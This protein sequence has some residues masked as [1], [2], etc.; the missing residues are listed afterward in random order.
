MKV[1]LTNPGV[2]DA[3]V[4]ICLL[5]SGK[6]IFY[7][8]P[9]ASS[10]LIVVGE[11]RGTKDQVSI[12]VSTRKRS[13]TSTLLRIKT[14]N[15][16]E[17]VLSRREA[18]DKDFDDAIFLNSNDEVAEATSSNIFWV[19]GKGIF[20][21][22]IECG[23]LPGITRELVLEVASELGYELNERKFRLPYLLNS[24]FAFLTNSLIGAIYISKINDQIMPNT[25]VQFV[26]YKEK[27]FER[28]GW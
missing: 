6:N 17:N 4:K 18:V 3:Y 15:Y 22:S 12:C 24:D 14:L 23:I 11:Y 8:K 27:L 25:P 20:T 1:L 10:L 21:P 28:L 7:H 13:S 19:R 16:L 2:D 5:S 9:E 26:E